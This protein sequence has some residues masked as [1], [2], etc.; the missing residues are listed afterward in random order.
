MQLKSAVCP[1]YVDASD[2]IYKYKDR[3]GNSCDYKWEGW[4]P[5]L[6]VNTEWDKKPRSWS[7]PVVSV[8]EREDSRDKENPV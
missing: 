7:W 8:T 1:A 4:L 3:G 5:E 2:I 6:T